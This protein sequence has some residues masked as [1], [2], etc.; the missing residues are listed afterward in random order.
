VKPVPHTENNALPSEPAQD[1]DVGAFELLEGIR[2]RRR[3]ESPSFHTLVASLKLAEK[4]SLGSLY[5]RQCRIWTVALLPNISTSFDQHA[6]AWVWVLWKLRM[7]PEFK[8][9]SGIMQ[10]QAKH[11]IDQD[12]HEYGVII[13]KHIVGK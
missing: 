2:D 10:Q 1:D 5:L 11:R 9:L 7:G 3:V 6:I 8:K 4:Y 13:P 12:T